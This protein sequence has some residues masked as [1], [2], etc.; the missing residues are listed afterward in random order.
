M[1]GEVTIDLTTLTGKEA[2]EVIALANEHNFTFG[3]QVVLM[4]SYNLFGAFYGAWFPGAHLTV[5]DPFIED[6][7]HHGKVLVA[8]ENGR[9]RRVDRAH[10]VRA[11]DW[12]EKQLWRLVDND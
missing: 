11:S 1:Q 9:T 8:T 6:R 5:L 3:E 4:E 2:D 7:I 12:E 10:L